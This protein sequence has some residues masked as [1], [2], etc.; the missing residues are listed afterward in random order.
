M[1]RIRSEGFDN[2][3][4]STAR[5]RGQTRISFIV[6]GQIWRKIVL[7]H[8]D[9]NIDNVSCNVLD[10]AYGGEKASEIFNMVTREL[11]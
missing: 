7:V 11:L 1:D 5:L 9:W 3:L 2:R 4:P 6:D 10:D 8:S